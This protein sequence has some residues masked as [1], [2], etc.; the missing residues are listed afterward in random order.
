MRSKRGFTLIELIVVILIIGI[1]AAVAAP[2]FFDTA[3]DARQNATKQSLHVVRDA[4]ELY[5]S[6]TGTYPPAATL[7]AALKP[8]LKGPFPAVQI[9]ANKNANVVAS[10]QDPIATPEAGGAG[11]VYNATTGE[12]AV[13]EAAYISW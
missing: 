8:Y 9:G 3:T 7:A 13:N 10:T 2:K 6:Q 1:L 4:L 11:W 12:V 5:R